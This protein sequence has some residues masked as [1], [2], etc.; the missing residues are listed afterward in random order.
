MKKGMRE[1]E[2]CIV[3]QR[4]EVNHKFVVMVDEARKAKTAT[5][6]TPFA[7]LEE[8]EIKRAQIGM[9]DRLGQVESSLE[10]SISRLDRQL[11]QVQ[12]H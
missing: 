9:V 6:Y 10:Y 11:Q 7:I 3:A 4:S 12:S 8:Q 5:N 1:M 2:D